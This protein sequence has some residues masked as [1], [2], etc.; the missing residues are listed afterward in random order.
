METITTKC[1]KRMTSKHL[2]LG[3]HSCLSNHESSSSKLCSTMHQLRNRKVK[4]ERLLIMLIF[5]ILKRWSFNKWN[6]CTVHV[7]NYPTICKYIQF[8]YVCKQ[9]CMFR[10][11]SPSMIR[12]SCHCIHTTWTW[13]D[14]NCISGPVSFT[15]GFRHGLT[16]ARWCGYSDMSSWWWV[17][18]PPETCRAIYRHK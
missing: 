16:N 11:V 8:I 13:P 2:K 10:V 5:V 17:E 7:N 18:I 4:K 3:L 14:G 6:I 1:Q 12:S 15:T 9:L